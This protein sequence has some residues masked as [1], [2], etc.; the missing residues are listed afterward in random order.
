MN[1]AD[2]LRIERILCPIDFSEFSARAYDYAQSLA[3][4]YQAK[5]FLN[6]V[7]DFG[8]PPYEYYTPA[9]DFERGLPEDFA[10]TLE[11]SCRSSRSR[12]RG[13]A[14]SLSASCKKVR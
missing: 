9:V 1:R 10:P 13:T 6:H 3:R 14:S 8:I 11:T 12:I 5:L 2:M 4:H 7:V